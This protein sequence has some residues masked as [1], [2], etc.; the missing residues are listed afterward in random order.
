[1]SFSP[2]CIV[3]IFCNYNNQDNSNYV[4]SYFHFACWAAAISY[5]SSQM[6]FHCG[7]DTIDALCLALSL[8]K[9]TFT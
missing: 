3:I 6:A 2:A 7:K 8:P 1:M 4:R 9:S 5:I